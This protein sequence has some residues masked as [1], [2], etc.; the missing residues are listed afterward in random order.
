MLKGVADRQ[1]LLSAFDAADHKTKKVGSIEGS[2]AAQA[3][4]QQ[5]ISFQ[6]VK[7]VL[8]EMEAVDQGQLDAFIYDTALLRYLNRDS[9]KNRLA[10]EATGLQTRRYV[11]ALPDNSAL[12][13][14]VNSQVMQEQT[15]SDWQ[16]LL[17][18]FLPKSES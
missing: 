1:F 11:F 13:E 4:K 7:G 10:V 3:L 8:A 16:S 14:T 15:E 9:F 2:S 12:L 6:P 17:K 5:Q 18:R